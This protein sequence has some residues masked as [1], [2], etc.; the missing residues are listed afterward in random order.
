M[1]RVLGV[2]MATAVLV[3]VGCGAEAGDEAALE[4]A[5]QRIAQLEEAA[6]D[7]S[8]SE[9]QDQDEVPETPETTAPPTTVPPTTV[10]PTTEP[11]AVTEPPQSQAL[12]PDV[13]CMNLQAAQ[14]HIQAETGVFL[15]LSEDATGAGRNQIIDSNWLVVS[16]RPAPG[17]PIGEGDAVLSAVKLGEPNS[18]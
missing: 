10:P 17:T 3:L 1:K 16:Q 9:V 11:P 4:E 5:N 13:V 8:T 15:S 12:M 2:A 18:C 7:S 14:D 6:S